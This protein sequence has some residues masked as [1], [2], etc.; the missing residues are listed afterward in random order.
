[1]LGCVLRLICINLLSPNITLTVKSVTWN[2]KGCMRFVSIVVDMDI[3]KGDAQTKSVTRFLVTRI[4]F[5]P[6]FADGDSR[7]EL[8]EEYGPCMKAKKKVRRNQQPIL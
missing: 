2:M 5:N 6:I 1:M 4:H 3:T 7:P 8:E